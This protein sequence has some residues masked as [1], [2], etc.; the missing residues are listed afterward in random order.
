MPQPA[1]SNSSINVKP[2]AVVMRCRRRLTKVATKKKTIS[3]ARPGAKWRRL[4]NG[5]GSILLIGGARVRTA[6]VIVS[7]TGVGAV[8]VGVTGLGENEQ[9]AKRGKPLQLR[10]TGC[11]NPPVEE[12]WRLKVAVWPAGMAEL[13]G[14]AD[15]VKSDCWPSPVPVRRTI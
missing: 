8:P 13:D 11:K 14:R 12:N 3:Q 7:A 5:C 9:A 15:S 1:I 6:V 10:A 4:V 2:K